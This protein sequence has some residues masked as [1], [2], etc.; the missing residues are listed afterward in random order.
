MST[1]RKKS[2]NS[3]QLIAYGR[4]DDNH[5]QKKYYRTWT[6]PEGMTPAAARKA[7]QRA[8]DEFEASLRGRGAKERIKF[9]AFVDKWLTDYAVPQLKPKTVDGY[10]GLLPVL[11]AEFG[12]LYLDEIDAAHLAMFY[13]KLRQTRKQSLYCCPKGFSEIMTD[14]GFTRN[15]LRTKAGVAES[16]ITS[17]IRGKNIRPI[18]AE[19][20][21]AAMGLPLSKVFQEVP[22]EHFLDANTVL[23]YHRVISSILQTAVTWGYIKENPAYTVA[24]PRKSKKPIKYLQPEEVF[25]LID[26]MDRDRV[27][28]KYRLALLAL[29]LTGMRRE[30]LLATR[31]K[32]IDFVHG[33]FEVVQ[34]VGYIRKKGLQFYST[35]TTG[36]YRVISLPD[37]MIDELKAYRAYKDRQLAPLG[38]C[39]QDSDYLFQETDGHLLWPSSVT[40]WVRKFYN[41]HPELQRITPHGLRHTNASIQLNNR[42]PLPAVSETLGHTN[43]QTTAAIYAHVIQSAKVAASRQV[44]SILAPYLKNR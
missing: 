36:S 24:T 4:Y 30:E 3:Y 10:I 20:I 18:S 31:W 17:A 40:S 23:H 2:Q 39:V 7:A 26:A 27:P 11:Q 44:D 43:S 35:K 12:T 37:C 22:S 1:V 34:A 41:R 15:S 33:T 9:S 42:T 19:K 38:L 14:H 16:V 32:D 28:A 8:A 25:A 5:V 13:S 6:I 29:V 21:A